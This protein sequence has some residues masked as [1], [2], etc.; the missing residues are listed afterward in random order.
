MLCIVT[1]DTIKFSSCD[2]T[3][4]AVTTQPASSSVAGRSVLRSTLLWCTCQSDVLPAA[5]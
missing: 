1:A 2:V 5:L 3:Q 4:Q